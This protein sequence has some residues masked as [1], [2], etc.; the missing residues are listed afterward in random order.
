MISLWDKRMVRKPVK[1]SWLVQNERGCH[2]R[3]T[4]HWEE[5]KS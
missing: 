4:N 3:R 5:A 1:V 2:K